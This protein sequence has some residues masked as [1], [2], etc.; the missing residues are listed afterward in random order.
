VCG[1]VRCSAL[2]RAAVRCS[3]DRPPDRGAHH[4]NQR[5]GE[6]ERKQPRGERARGERAR[7]EWARGE[8]A[9]GEQGRE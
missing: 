7:G 1:A 4:L 6:Q 3:V 8:W 9:R 5:E 2:Q